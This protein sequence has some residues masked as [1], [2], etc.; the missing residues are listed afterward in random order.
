MS[1]PKTL[2]VHSGTYKTGSSSIQL[3]LSRTEQQGEL[4]EASYPVTGRS[5]NTVQHGNLVAELRSAR[6]H[7][8]RLGTWDDLLRELVDGPR[9]TAIVSSE[10]FSTLT[11]EQIGALGARC[12]AAGVGIRWV[13]YLREQAGLYNAFYVERL[14]NM[15]PEFVDLIDLPFEDFGTWSPIDMGFLEFDRFIENVLAA[16]P[17]VD[18]VVRPFIRSHL[19]GG[20]VIADF[21]AAV[22]IPYLENRGGAA[23]IGS[24]WRTTE[25]ARRLTPVIASADIGRR[26]RHKENPTAAR[27]RWLQLIR[28]EL[29]AAT[30]ELGWNDESAVYLEPAFRA[31]LHDRYRASNERVAALTGL[32]WPGMVAAEEQRDHNIGDYSTIDGAELMTVVQRVLGT[33]LVKP[34]EIDQ[35]PRREKGVPPAEAGADALGV[36][37]RAARRVLRRGDT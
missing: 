6:A 37:R 21:C 10:H 27:M 28:R 34:A 9:H 19:V 7:V 18:L 31:V 1:A 30:R 13:H 32:D 15:R 2:V 11:S 24:G 17:G 12:E 35:L 23:N 25:T 33:T 14:V 22:G 8:P 26:V 29:S 20:D 3:Y 36:A 4:G 5:T 16:I